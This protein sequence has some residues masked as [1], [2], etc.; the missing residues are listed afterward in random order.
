MSRPTLG[1][2]SRVSLHSL[3]PLGSQDTATWASGNGQGR[4]QIGLN[5]QTNQYS[6]YSKQSYQLSNLSPGG[7]LTFKL[8]IKQPAQHRGAA[9]R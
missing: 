8:R 9:L 7:Y 1:F 2:D 6:V 3:H 4:L 5:R